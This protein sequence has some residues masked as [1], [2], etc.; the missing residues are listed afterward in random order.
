MKTTKINYQ[1]I[2]AKWAAEHKQV[3]L[4]TKT[5]KYCFGG[6]SDRWGKE[7]K[8]AADNGVIVFVKESNGNKLYVAPGYQFAQ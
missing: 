1:E 2:I 4:D 6:T 5:A 7:L 8:I 3:H